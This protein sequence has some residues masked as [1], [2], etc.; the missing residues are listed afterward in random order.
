[1]TTLNTHHKG[2]RRVT[3]VGLAL[4]LSLFTA[5][6]DKRPR[7]IIE[8]PQVI[9]QPLPVVEAVADIQFDGGVTEVHKMTV[10]NGSLYLTGK[11]FA[12][13]RWNLSADP[14]S[15][16]VVFAASDNINNEF[17]PPDRFGPW[18]P[19][20]YASGALA[21]QG[22]RAY[23]SGTAGMSV[24]DFSDTHHPVEVSR[25]PAW[26]N[27]EPTS[28]GRFVYKAMLKQPEKNRIFGFRQQDY[29]YALS[30]AGFPNM[31][32]LGNVSYPGGQACCASSI[33]RF[34][35]KIFLALGTSMQIY[36]F[37]ST[38]SLHYLGT[39]N[40]LNVVNVY[41]T[42]R[43]LYLHHRPISS[44]TSTYPTGIYVYDQS[45]GYVTSLPI[46][47]NEFAVHDLDTH[48]YVNDNDVSVRVYRVLWNN[49]Q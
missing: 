44:G 26:Q 20:L 47:P 18:L 8:E 23:M 32:L 15:P 40:N 24:V 42:S 28:D 34:A 30:T 45:L 37:T 35:G 49:I 13:S 22:S 38:G 12:F 27:D 4:V 25:Y 11:P 5:C 48:V 17:A 2:H 1:M 33:A 14:E 21:V 41:A 46:D 39:V 7:E 6:T 10:D 16:T 29:I 9:S 3:V 36:E 19:D 43:Y 31:S